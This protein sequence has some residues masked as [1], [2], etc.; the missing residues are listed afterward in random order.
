MTKKIEG[1]VPKD[2]TTFFRYSRPLTEEYIM[3]SPRLSRIPPMISVSQ[4][5]PDRSLPITINAV[6]AL[7]VQR[8]Y[9]LNTQFPIR[10]L[11]CM[12]AVGMTHMTSMVVDDG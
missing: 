8:I 9:R 12:A 5:T 2:N 11:S 3:T 4:C 7:I 6:K 10:L 1:R